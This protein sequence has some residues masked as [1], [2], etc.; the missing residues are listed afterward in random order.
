M[1]QAKDG[2]GSR[3]K[4]KGGSVYPRINLEDAIQFARKLVS[5]THSA[6]QPYSTIFPGVFGV[7]AKNTQGQVRASA[8]KQ[9]GLLEGKPEAY[10]ATELAKKISVAIPEEIQSYLQQ[11]CLKPKVFRVLFDTFHG[12]SV[13]IARLKQQ[14]ASARVHPDEAENCAT[15]FA[16]GAVFAKLAIANGEAFTIASDLSTSQQPQTTVAD[17]QDDAI[18]GRESAIQEPGTPLAESNATPPAPPVTPT[19]PPREA[20]SASARSIIHVNVTIDSSLDTD[21]LEK[22]LILLR[23]YGAL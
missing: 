3:L 18:L 23:K 22:Q 10:S 21:K 17:Q 9:Y 16:E 4:K 6:P 2:S 1:A 5:K 7:A 13:T 14:A 15:L 20:I 19:P 8:L 12:D 11:A